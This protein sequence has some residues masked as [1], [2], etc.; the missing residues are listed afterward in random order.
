MFFSKQEHIILGVT[1]SNIQL[2]AELFEFLNTNPEIKEALTPLFNPYPEDEKYTIKFIKQSIRHFVEDSH[3][4]VC[5][6]VT[7]GDDSYAVG[8]AIYKRM[9][10]PRFKIGD[11]YWGKRKLLVPEKVTLHFRHMR[12]IEVP[13]YCNRVFR[14]PLHLRF[15]RASVVIQPSYRLKK[16]FLPS[17]IF[18]KNHMAPPE[19]LID[20]GPIG[21]TPS[22]YNLLPH[23]FAK[24]ISIISD[25][26][27]FRKP[28]IEL[29]LSEEEVINRA[30]KSLANKNK[31][32]ER[33]DKEQEIVKSLKASMIPKSPTKSNDEY[34]DETF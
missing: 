26:Y 34:D 3:L 31:R 30:N 22:L 16:P 12:I 32:K 25:L 19:E 5:F 2:H 4:Y 24:D 1:R 10:A 28:K 29:E 20:K 18:Y 27:N 6:E 17:E 21:Q 7:G 15:E 9:W 14:V 11:Y 13:M 23:M 33:E 8:V